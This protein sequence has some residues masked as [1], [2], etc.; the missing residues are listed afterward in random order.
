MLGDISLDPL[1]VVGTE[2]IYGLIMTA[3]VIMPIAAAIPGGDV[4]Q[5]Y[6]NTADSILMLRDSSLDSV[7]FLY[8]LGLWGLNALGMMVTKHLGGVFRA[9]ST[10]LQSLFVWLIDLGLF[11][12]LGTG[13]GF[14]I[15]EAWKGEGSWLQAFGFVV[16]VAGTLT[17]AYGNS[18]QSAAISKLPSRVPS[19]KEALLDEFSPNTVNNAMSKVRAGSIDSFAF[20]MNEDDLEIESL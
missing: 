12:G 7:L 17:Y 11:Y 6:E 4:G 5:V 14:Q 8:L 1:Q 2:G 15:G 16:L 18:V 19:L 10:N 9:V 3:C 20:L 13:F